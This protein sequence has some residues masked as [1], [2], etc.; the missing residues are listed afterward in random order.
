MSK[1]IDNRIIEHVAKILGEELT[2]S[3]IDDMFDQLGLI[4]LDKIERGYTSTK[5]RRIHE[6]VLVKC[7]ENNSALPFFLVIQYVL[8]PSSYIDKPDYWKKI[9]RGINSQLMFYGFEVN[10]AGRVIETE[11]V[12]S[13]GDGQRRLQSFTERLSAYEIHPEILKYCTDELFSENYFHAILEAS[14]GL[15]HRLREMSGLDLDGSTLV[16][17]AFIIRKP[18]IVIN[19]NKME[20]LTEKSEYNGLKSLLNTIVYL[21]RNPKAH[22]PKLY[23]PSSESDAVTA[24]TLMSM[25]HSILDN[26]IRVR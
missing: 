6:S 18:V 14:K 4:N 21:Y 7:K 25:A 5:W 15:L 17:E 12:E 3:K 8:T 16:N 26:C 23:N 24:F 11:V 22:E 2:G 19:G 9:L 10:D 13:F 20:S 1:P